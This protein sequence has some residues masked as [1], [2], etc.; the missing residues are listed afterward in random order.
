MLKPR[1]YALIYRT[2][3]IALPA[4]R[5]VK[6]HWPKK[7]PSSVLLAVRDPAA[8]ARSLPDGIKTLKEVAGGIKCLRVEVGLNTT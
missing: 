2:R 6:T 7:V 5:P 4:V 3:A 1:L 8:E